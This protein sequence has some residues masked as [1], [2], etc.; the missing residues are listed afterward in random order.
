MPLM[1][2]KMLVLPAPLGPMTARK[3]WGCTSRL[4]P[5]RAVTPPKWRCTPSRLSSAMP[6]RRPLPDR[7]AADRRL[8]RALQPTTVPKGYLGN[9]SRACAL[10]RGRSDDARVGRNLQAYR[11]LVNRPYNARRAPTRRQF[12]KERA[13]GDD[14]AAP[15]DRAV[16]PRQPAGRP[17]L[18]QA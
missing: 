14:P 11:G 9:P 2:L 12:F 1:Q 10:P 3:S 16:P 18:V 13:H 8:R 15:A 5:A 17:D 4:T 6:S 7:R